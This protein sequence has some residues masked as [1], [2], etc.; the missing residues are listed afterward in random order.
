MDAIQREV[1]VAEYAGLSARPTPN[2]ASDNDQHA[3]RAVSAYE[4]VAHQDKRDILADMLGV[5]EYA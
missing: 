3:Q 1:L 4:A 2:H 5:S